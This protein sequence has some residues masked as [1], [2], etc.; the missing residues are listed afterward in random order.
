MTKSPIH[1]S[2]QGPSVSRAS[3]KVSAASPVL[4][5]TGFHGARLQ[6]VR[7]VTMRWYRRGFRRPVPIN[8]IVNKDPGYS[9]NEQGYFTMT[10]LTRFIF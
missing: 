8:Y 10:F 9:R 6:A 5:I 7:R 4:V 2:R 1:T 3:F